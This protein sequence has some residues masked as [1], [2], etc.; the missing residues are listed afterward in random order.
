MYKLKILVDTDVM[1]DWVCDS[2]CRNENA[3]RIVG[4]CVQQGKIQGYMAA[5][6]FLDVCRAIGER[7]DPTKT[8]EKMQF[9][10]RNF[11]ILKLDRKLALKALETSTGNG[12]DDGLIAYSADSE[13]IDFII[14]REV[15]KFQGLMDNIPKS[16]P[17][18]LLA[19]LTNVKVSKV[20]A[21]SPEGFLQ[22]VES[23]G[24]ELDLNDSWGLVHRNSEEG[25]FPK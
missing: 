17:Q 8:G 25:G 24:Q 12:L 18:R 6:I 7:H 1:L 3:M 13:K 9:L 16:T 19:K 23:V 10:Y 2:D 5:N 22:L 11:E 20:K 14:T 15:A 21:L 4:L